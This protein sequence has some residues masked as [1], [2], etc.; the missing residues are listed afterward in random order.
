M[1]AVMFPG[2]GSQS[3]GMSSSILST[4]I[5]KTYFE[6]TNN[7]LAYFDSSDDSWGYI[8]SPD[9]ISYLP[10]ELVELT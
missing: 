9:E 10:Q 6:H 2:Q 1:F 3:V 7:I 4:E 5:A 8:E